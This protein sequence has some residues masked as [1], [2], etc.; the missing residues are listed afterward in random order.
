MHSTDH[1]NI[2]PRA[3]VY[4]LHHGRR[5]IVAVAPD[6]LPQLY[7]VVWPDIGPSPPVN[8][9]RAKDAA[10]AWAE[11]RLWSTEHRKNGAARALKSLDNFSW[12]SPLVREI[13]NSE[14]MMGGCAN[15][16]AA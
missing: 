16:R 1:A 11:H 12:S 2:T 9:S 15:E 4:H 6:V 7:R 3:D 10:M 13:E 14:R 8:L 5:L